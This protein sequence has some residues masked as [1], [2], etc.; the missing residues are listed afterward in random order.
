MPIAI[1]EPFEM[2]QYTY[3]LP[4]INIY[5]GAPN[6]CSITFTQISEHFITTPNQLL[7]A[8]AHLRNF[9]ISLIKCYK[10]LE[11]LLHNSS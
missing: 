7:T 3:Q 5:S 6:N 2:L 1:T 10:A 8:L 4:Q 11:K 9:Y